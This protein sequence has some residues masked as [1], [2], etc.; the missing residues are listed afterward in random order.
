MTAKTIS[1]IRP[2]RFGKID[3]SKER[4]WVIKHGQEYV[5]QWIVLGEG[6]LIG[7]TTDGDALLA[8]VERARSEG[9]RVPYVK[10]ISGNTEPIWMGWL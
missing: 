7:H 6:R 10:F 9:I 3:L 1:P 8:I 5:G 4:E 2:S